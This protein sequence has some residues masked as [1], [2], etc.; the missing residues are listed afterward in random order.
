MAPPGKSATNKRFA[1][2]VPNLPL[3]RRPPLKED[4]EPLDGNDFEKEEDQWLEEE[5]KAT[6]WLGLFYGQSRFR[7]I[8]NK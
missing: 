6:E 8:V 7:R 2:P 3:W 1:K 5:G 4:R